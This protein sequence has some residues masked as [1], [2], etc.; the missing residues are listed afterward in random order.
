MSNDAKRFYGRAGVHECP[1]DP[2]MMITLE[3]VEKNLSP[4]SAS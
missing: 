1:A 4:P 2:M 3:E